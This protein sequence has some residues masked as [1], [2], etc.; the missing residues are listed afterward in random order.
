MSIL[1][2]PFAF[3]D[4]VRG[5]A[6]PGVH[7]DDPVARMV[8]RTSGRLRPE[9]AYRRRLRSRVMNQYVAT[10]EGLMPVVARRRMTPIG[11][12]VLY[13]S[14]ALACSVTAVGAASQ[15][16]LPGDP[17]YAVKRQIEDVRIQIAPAWVRPSLAAMALD[18]RLGE[19]EELANAGRWSLVAATVADVQAA[20]ATLAAIG[21]P[22]APDLIARLEHHGEVLAAIAASAPAA[23][24]DG[25]AR[26]MA[27][28][29]R[30]LEV[31]ATRGGSGSGAGPAT[32]SGNGGGAGGKSGASATPQPTKPP[33]PT[34]SPKATPSPSPA[35]AS[36]PPASPPGPA[37][38]PR[39]AAQS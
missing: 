15:E 33:K 27:A 35:P 39:S 12:A 31:T 21:G 34:A 14:V 37:A 36:N 17:L 16:A 2:A 22:I 9:P 28:S 4:R 24:E 7:A 13:A 11:R 25:L 30:A 23:A 1:D 10:R 18:E 29:T 20:E 38:S 8:A 19:V 3:L 5:R 6:A 32:G 26:A